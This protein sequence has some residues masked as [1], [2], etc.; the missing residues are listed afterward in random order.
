MEFFLPSILLIIFA[1]VLVFAVLPKFTP[2]LL[3]V[4]A[5]LCLVL[6]VYN[7]YSLFKNEYKIM[8]WADTA[9]QFSPYLLSGLVIVLL[10]GYLLYLTGSGKRVTLPMP[11]AN[12]PPPETA[13]NF[14]TEAI[15]NGL[16]S[17]GVANVSPA[18]PSNNVSNS[19]LSKGI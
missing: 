14:V 17:T 9:T 10:V 6:A 19:V 16:V 4:V 3:A 18:P 15:G 13:T 1:A 2:L 11:S 8:T 12:I 7:H 5:L